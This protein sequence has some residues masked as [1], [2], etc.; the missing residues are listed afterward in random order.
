MVY[1][2]AN[3]KTKSAQSSPPAL[4]TAHD[5]CGSSR[6]TLLLCRQEVTLEAGPLGPL[7]LPIYLQPD[8]LDNGT[9]CTSSAPL[10]SASPETIESTL[11]SL[12]SDEFPA[13]LECAIQ[14]LEAFA[15]PLGINDARASG[16]ITPDCE[17]VYES[18]C[19]DFLPDE[20]TLC[21]SRRKIQASRL[22]GRTSP[23]EET[24][25]RKK[26]KSPLQRTVLFPTLN[27]KRRKTRSLTE[28]EAALNNLRNTEYSPRHNWTPS[29]RELLCI[30]HRFYEASPNDLKQVFNAMTSNDLPLRKVRDQFYSHIV[31]YGDKVYPFYGDVF[32][33][34]IDDPSGSYSSIRSLIDNTARRLNIKLDRRMGETVIKSG[35]AATARCIRI[36]H[37]HRELVRKA[38]RTSQYSSIPEQIEP[39][40]QL[41][42]RGRAI[43]S[44]RRNAEHLIDPEDG[45]NAAVYNSVNLEVTSD[46]PQ[47]AFRAWDEK[48]RTKYDPRRGF[49][50]QVHTYWNGPVLPPLNTET[51]EGRGITL[52]LSN[53]HLSFEGDFS[54]YVS[55]GTSLLYVLN[56]ASNMENPRLA[57]IDL[58]ARVL[59]EPHKM[60][61]AASLFR[62][63]R[64]NG[65]VVA[66][67][68]LFRSCHCTYS[69]SRP[70]IEN[71]RRVRKC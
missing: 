57:L 36:R 52:L 59:Q 47:L 54:T 45:S 21:P 61:S 4:P 32:R 34:P 29:E 37:R 70:T 51:E 30:L 48:S 68:H 15:H 67:L 6:G 31:Y 28:N 46:T 2:P 14:Q 58:N 62:E 23:P 71:T 69:S 9:V 38:Q 55:V 26:R 1:I 49:I 8:D 16:L 27:N 25:S 41:L 17:S 65:Q 12:A 10:L 66:P 39:A 35:R 33:C 11:P 20:A 56:K 5:K 22:M 7:S 64:Q 24:R 44:P 3:E 42:F 53:L 50:P 13:R 40:G 60:L 18:E 43:E 63:L 19:T